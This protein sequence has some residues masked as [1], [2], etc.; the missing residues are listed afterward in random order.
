MGRPD[1]SRLC[2]DP[3]T[4]FYF[5]PAKENRPDRSSRPGAAFAAR[6]PKHKLENLYRY[7]V[8]YDTYLVAKVME[9]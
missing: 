9:S 5:V 7:V 2:G 8:D 6:C 1:K 3:A 4:T